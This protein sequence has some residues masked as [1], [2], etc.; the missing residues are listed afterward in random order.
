[1]T[2]SR[3]TWRWNA[4]SL[5]SLVAIACLVWLLWQLKDVLLV[6]VGCVFFA[7][8]LAPLVDRLEHLP[9]GRSR[10]LGRKPAAGITVLL[11]TYLVVQAVISF[12]PVLWSDIQRLGG[13]LPTYYT[14]GENWLR[15]Q[16]DRHGMGLPSEVWDRVQLEWHV[17]LEKGAMYLGRSLTGVIG[18]A[19]SLLGL[20]VVPIGAFYILSDG[21]ALAHGFVEGLPVTWRPMTHKLLEEADRSLETYV[22]GQTLVVLVASVLAVALFTTLGL[23]YSLALGLL[24]GMAEA[25]PFLG[26]ISVVAALALVGSDRGLQF[27]LVSIGA[28]LALNQVN[29][30]LISPR[31]MSAQ[32]SLHPLVVIFAV[33]AGTSLG[34]VLG[35]VLALPTA[36]LLV[37][38]GGVLW[39]AGRPAKPAK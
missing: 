1:V 37:G 13:E 34:G 22:R 18:L 20:L 26:S 33:L 17:L 6:L 15:A 36:A 19:G 39:G 30:Y 32:L 14:M 28:Y 29:N 23:R 25:V 24:A 21:P 2:T 11:A 38:L 16:S 3:A 4:L 35:A 27:V 9:L 10:R 31:L 5:G 8:V 7:Y 12:V